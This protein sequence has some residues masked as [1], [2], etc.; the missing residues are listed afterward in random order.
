MPALRTVRI[1]QPIEGTWPIARA[2]FRPQWQSLQ[3]AMTRSEGFW[4]ASSLPFSRRRKGDQPDISPEVIF[5]GRHCEPTGPAE[6]AGST[7]GLREAIQP[8]R[9]A[10]RAATTGQCY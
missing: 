8:Q 10:K 1:A 6:A 3:S 5:L 2:P 9:M 4:I 7:I